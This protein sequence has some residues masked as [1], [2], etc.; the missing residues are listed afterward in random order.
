[1]LTHILT[2]LQKKSQTQNLLGYK[3]KHFIV[4]NT[5][6][7]ISELKNFMR[8]SSATAAP[9]SFDVRSIDFSGM[10]PSIPL[11]D[12][13]DQVD[14][15]C[16]LFWEDGKQPFHKNHFLTL[17]YNGKCYLEKT[18]STTRHSWSRS[19][20]MKIVK[21]LLHNQVLTNFGLN[22]TQ[23]LG[24]PQGSPLSPV[25]ANMYLAAYEWRYASTDEIPVS[26]PPFLFLR[27]LDDVLVINFDIMS[28][29]QRMYPDAL[30]FLPD[31]PNPFDFSKSVNPPF[32][33]S[34]FPPSPSSPNTLSLKFLDL[35]IIF[36]KSGTT[37]HWT[38]YDKRASM[39]NLPL[40]NKIPQKSSLI[41]TKTINGVIIGQLLRLRR[42][43][44]HFN[45]FLPVAHAYALYA[46]EKN[47]ARIAAFGCQRF[48]SRHLPQSERQPFLSRILPTLH[49]R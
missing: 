46:A 36:S 34:Q 1:M 4:N 2:T 5:Q 32:L 44:S 18:R 10:Y 49:T 42:N 16:T 45:V 17:G 25:L 38:T 14:W 12:C 41:H 26:G 7:V 33:R 29:G 9:Q 27:F 28:H 8:D 39:A 6:D 35:E 23:T 20:L 19:E 11:D 40:I 21:V 43:S 13:I 31:N 15:L 24:L 22:F 47:D 48:A 37:L 3:R 30:K